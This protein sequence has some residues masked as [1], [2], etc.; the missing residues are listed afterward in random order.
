MLFGYRGCQIPQIGIYPKQISLRREAVVLDACTLFP[1]LPRDVLLTIP[2][3]ATLR[4]ERYPNASST[5]TVLREAL[6]H[7]AIPA[8]LLTLVSPTSHGLTTFRGTRAAPV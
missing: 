8:P 6:L 4:A 3:N 5:A 1:M 7:R 2:R